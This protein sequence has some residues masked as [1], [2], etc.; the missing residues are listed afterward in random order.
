MSLI[1]RFSRSR[2]STSLSHSIVSMPVTISSIIRA[3]FGPRVAGRL[4]EGWK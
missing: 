3:I 1:S 2:A 4:A